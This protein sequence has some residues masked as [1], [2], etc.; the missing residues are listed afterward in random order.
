MVHQL[1]IPISVIPPFPHQDL[2][3]IFTREGVLKRTIHSVW[4][5]QGHVF[6]SLDGGTQIRGYQVRGSVPAKQFTV[7]AKVSPVVQLCFAKDTSD[8]LLVFHKNG[9]VKVYENFRPQDSSTPPWRKRAQFTLGASGSNVS[10]KSA[11]YSRHHGNSLVWVEERKEAESVFFNLLS[12]ELE[13][14]CKGIKSPTVLLS[15]CPTELMIF[16]SYGGDCILV[17]PRK[18]SP[19]GLYFKVHANTG[20][21]TVELASSILGKGCVRR[22]TVFPLDFT[23][24]AESLIHRWSEFS[25]EKHSNVVAMAME[26]HTG[27]MFLIA[28]NATVHTISH[29]GD[30][31]VA[32][33]SMVDVDV[34][35][36]SSWFAYRFLLGAVFSDEAMIRVFSS[37]CGDLL[38][39]ISL[40]EVTSTKVVHVWNQAGSVPRLG[41]WS[42]N[43]IWILQVSMHAAPAA[44]KADASSTTEQLQK[45]GLG[46]MA[47][48]LELERAHSQLSRDESGGGGEGG[49]GGGEEGA[50]DAG[51][52]LEI[53][54]D[55]AIFQ[56]E[57]LLVNLLQ[58]AGEHHKPD[59][60]K[61]LE[62][63]QQDHEQR[64]DR[65]PDT[66]LN[67]SMLPLL[68][69]FW[70]IQKQRDDT[71]KDGLRSR[72]GPT[73]AGEV[74]SCLE[75]SSIPLGLRLGRLE[76]ISQ[77]FPGRVLQCLLEELDLEKA[78][79][80]E[81]PG[82][83]VDLWSERAPQSCLRYASL[84]S[85]G[86]EE[87]CRFLKLLCRL[88]FLHQPA[89]LV[90][91]VEYFQMSQQTA[92]D[93]TAFT[94]KRRG[95]S[96]SGV[97]VDIL[98]QP[99]RSVNIPEAVEA[100]AHLIRQSDKDHGSMRALQLLLSHA[101]W[102]A[103]IDVVKH[104][105]PQNDLSHRELFHVL[106]CAILTDSSAMQRYNSDLWACLPS[107]VSALNLLQTLHIN[108]NLTKNQLSS[109]RDAPRQ[110]A[111]VQG[112]TTAL[113][114]AQL[115]Q[116]LTQ[117]SG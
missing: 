11:T 16:A 12:A 102:E 47:A 70:Q 90:R 101:M 64:K 55:D 87:G 13:P 21:R 65:T 71:A 14:Y 42:E 89:K 48:S 25:R 105:V 36:T 72:C 93:T 31:V 23:E 24:H 2:H 27:Q 78:M 109:Q 54:R 74:K 98:P 39:E 45:Y 15:R 84:C 49:G 68:D 111:Q 35:A 22:D 95:I 46:R 41:V 30:E 79:E 53:L 73:V 114:K 40:S 103:A 110:A 60:A 10:V 5:C 92:Q 37:K 108:E 50:S 32:S 104:H 59:F 58:G 56:N 28:D 91:A 75:D 99:T 85:T 117:E 107:S 34:M 82:G 96:L 61:G 3:A 52:N 62:E 51:L 67:E 1:I 20:E 80:T 57:A 113:L 19:A 43:G 26:P 116:M 97:L 112:L 18:P 38:Q 88:L 8:V 100:L 106:L 66:T 115:I 81:S 94:R 6:L 29:D 83:T 4:G 33:F 63:L 44:A 7:S 69:D 77:Q 9:L 17:H 86:T 76:L